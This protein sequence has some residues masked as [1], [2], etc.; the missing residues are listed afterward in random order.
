MKTKDHHLLLSFV[1]LYVILAKHLGDV[2]TLICL[3]LV[4]KILTCFNSICS[5]KCTSQSEL[6]LFQCYWRPK[7]CKS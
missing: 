2:N 5:G 4:L 1:P 3:E 7:W 6:L